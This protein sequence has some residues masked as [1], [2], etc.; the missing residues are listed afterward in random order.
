VLAALLVGCG[1]GNMSG[2]VTFNSKPVVFGT[3]L[4][5]GKDGLRQ[6]A[7]QPDGSFTVRDIAAGEARVAINSP[8]PKGIQ[9]Y[10]NKNP[11]YK[12][13][14]YPDVPGWFPIPKQYEDV[15]TS[16][17]KYTIRGG[18]NAIDIELK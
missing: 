16:G 7:I 4:V 14:P 12:Q 6:G 8:N 10:P 3:V 5:H 1:R 9:L 2:K 15:Q 18:S 11:K 17:L 13:E